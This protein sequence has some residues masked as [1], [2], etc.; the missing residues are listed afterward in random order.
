VEISKDTGNT[1]K[2]RLYSIEAA[3]DAFEEMVVVQKK[4]TIKPIQT[5]I[6][7]IEHSIGAIQDLLSVAMGEEI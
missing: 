1:L 5:H 3:L 6:K 2:G 4:G 7:T